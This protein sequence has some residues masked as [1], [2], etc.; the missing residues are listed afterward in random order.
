M[1]RVQ[2]TGKLSAT[3]RMRMPR[4]ENLKI[5]LMMMPTAPKKKTVSIFKRSAPLCKNMEHS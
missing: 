5:N 1:N 4:N 3:L 2:K